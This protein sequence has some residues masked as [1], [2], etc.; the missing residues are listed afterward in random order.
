MYL[1]RRLRVFSKSDEDDVQSR[2]EERNRR[3][4]KIA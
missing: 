3:A 2:E 1:S 4:Y